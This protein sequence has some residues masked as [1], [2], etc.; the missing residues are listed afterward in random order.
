MRH[1]FN[2]KPTIFNDKKYA[3]RLEASY[4]QR[5]NT[6]KDRGE[7]IFWLEQVPF[8]LPGNL[9][10]KIDFME[11]WKA[12]DGQETGDIVCTEVKGMET[13]DWVMRKKLFESTYPIT[14]NIVKK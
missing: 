10:Y 14:L 11:F 6:A 3:S 13:K 4:A 1:K 5:L 8:S 12:K 7:L 2:A 9:K